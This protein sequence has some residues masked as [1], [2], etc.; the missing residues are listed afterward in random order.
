[1]SAKRRNESE[2]MSVTIQTTTAQLSCA[3]AFYAAVR[4]SPMGSFFYGTV[5]NYLSYI[6]LKSLL[7]YDKN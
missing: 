4:H 1:L 3:T 5:P 6:I 2:P 7:N